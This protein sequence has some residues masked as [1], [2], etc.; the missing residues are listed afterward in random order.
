[1]HRLRSRHLRSLGRSRSSLEI[2]RQP[3]H[4]LHE[5]CSG[6]RVYEA[7]GPCLHMFE[8]RKRPHLFGFLRHET[9]GREDCVGGRVTPSSFAQWAP[10][11]N[12][13]TPF[14]GAR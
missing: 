5:I 7:S 10:R 9:G 1:M 3:P 2:A 14:L 13:V 12:L 11:I 8:G 6:A 4:T